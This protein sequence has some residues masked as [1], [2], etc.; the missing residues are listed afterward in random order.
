MHL[1]AGKQRT[2]EMRDELS[3]GQKIVHPRYGAGTVTHVRAG[4]IHEAPGRYYVIDIPSMAL[5]V[6]LPA[7]RL[8][9]V[10]VRDL[11]SKEKI[12]RALGVLG[13]QGADLPRDAR[14][15]CNALAES[16]ADGAV[17][18]LATVIRDLHSL[19]RTKALSLR[20]SSLLTQAK[21][22][23]AGEVALVTGAEV[24]EALRKIES[25]L[26]EAPAT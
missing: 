7:D 11:A 24:A 3:I 14:E 18:S 16:M 21:R 12:R 15:R 9:E 1:S 5:T 22:Q 10:Q 26:H 20:E 8:Q 25:A 13:S 4:R 2:N 6:H 23:L 19:Q 17:A